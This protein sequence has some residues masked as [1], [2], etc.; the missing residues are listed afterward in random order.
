MSLIKGC[1]DLV[2]NFIA[3]DADHR[4]PVCVGVLAPIMVNA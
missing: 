1:E 2:S 4:P 3:E